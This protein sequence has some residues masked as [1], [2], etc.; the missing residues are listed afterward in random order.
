MSHGT[1]VFGPLCQD[2]SLCATQVAGSLMFPM[3]LFN[4]GLPKSGTSTLHRTLVEAGL[5]SAHWE[6]PGLGHVGPAIYRRYFE[7]RDP[8]A[9]FASFDATTQADYVVGNVSIW[10]QMDVALI[11]RIL[12]FHPECS[13]LL[14]RRKPEQIVDS[15]SRWNDMLSRINAVG[16]P[17]LPAGYA[18]DRGNAVKW[19]ET[20][21]ANCRQ[22]FGG[23][24]RYFETDLESPDA[25]Q[26]IQ[27]AA[28]AELSWWGRENENPKPDTDAA[29]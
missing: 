15:M 26:V 29:A 8:L 3:R 27:A 28:R 25:L 2:S 16:A 1:T 20:H 5:K 7:G 22:H 4:L 11:R 18:S 17:G 13:L 14:L 19:I 21:Y 24:R 12:S 23:Y 9:D 6:V 10:P